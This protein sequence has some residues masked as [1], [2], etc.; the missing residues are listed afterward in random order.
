MIF[1]LLWISLL[2]IRCELI[3]FSCEKAGDIAFTFDQGPSYYTGVLLNTLSKLK[4]KATFHVD[5]EWLSNPVLMAYLK[6]TVNDGHTIG[7]FIKQ[8][9]LKD[10][11]IRA[12]ILQ[13]SEILLRKT[14]V[15]VKFLRFQ[16]PT[17]NDEF[18]KELDNSGYVVTTYNLDAQDYEFQKNVNDSHPIFQIMKRAFDQIVPPAL[19]SFIVVQHDG[20][21]ESVRQ[22]EMIIDYAI[23]KGYT[24]VSMEECVK[25][26]VSII[27]DPLEGP[28]VSSS[29]TSRKYTLFLLLI[30]FLS[31]LK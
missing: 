11:Q 30:C 24:P 18:L 26:S 25:E 22:S 20:I 15:T 8:N 13:N 7:L 4:I 16:I 9:D 21:Q 3:H 14:G 19:G 17:P 5:V 23:Q 31:H 12:L 2:V 1:K 29:A 27:P 6:R 28:T 10:E